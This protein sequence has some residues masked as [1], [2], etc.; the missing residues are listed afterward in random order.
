M[1]VLHGWPAGSTH[2]PLLSAGPCPPPPTAALAVRCGTAAPPARTPTGGRAATGACASCWA[3]SGSSAR[4]RGRL[5]QQQLRAAIRRRRNKPTSMHSIISDPLCACHLCS[6][7]CVSTP[8]CFVS[9]LRL[10][11]SLVLQPRRSQVKRSGWSGAAERGEG[12]GAGPG[13]TSRS[14]RFAAGSGETVSYGGEGR[15]GCAQRSK[16]E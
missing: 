5:L 14:G 6:R 9:T 8:I 16:T 12:R 3:R 7:L 11:A 4:R 2:S 10:R 15:R 13:T 1:P